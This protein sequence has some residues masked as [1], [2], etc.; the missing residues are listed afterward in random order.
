MTVT[1]TGED[2][3]VEPSRP[4][5]E[6]QGRFQNWRPQPTSISAKAPPLRH[7]QC[8]IALSPCS[9]STR[10]TA[11][12][13]PLQPLAPACSRA[14]IRGHPAQEANVPPWIVDPP[15]VKRLCHFRIQ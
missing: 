15:N 3:N 1:E 8:A 6:Q 4:S 5:H 2:P 10:C 13:A 14:E 9:Y 7:S 12:V 11:P